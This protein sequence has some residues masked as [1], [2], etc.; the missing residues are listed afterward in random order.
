[1]NAFMGRAGDAPTNQGSS[2]AGA[3]EDNLFTQLMSQRR[4]RREEHLN[5][6]RGLFDNLGGLLGGSFGKMSNYAQ[7][8]I[9]GDMYGQGAEH[10]LPTTDDNGDISLVYRQVC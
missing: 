1:M 9:V 2:G 3:G 4:Q 10:G 8:T 6:M 7:E 5:E